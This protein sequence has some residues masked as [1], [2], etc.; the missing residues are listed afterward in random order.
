MYTHSPCCSSSPLFGVDTHRGGSVAGSDLWNPSQVKRF[1]RALITTL[2]SPFSSSAIKQL[3]PSAFH[4]RPVDQVQLLAELV[5]LSPSSRAADPGFDSRLRRGDFYRVESYQRLKDF[6]RAES[7]QRLRDFYRAESYQR[8]R[9]FYRAES[10]QRLRDFYRAESYQRLRDF[11]RAES[12]QRLRDIYRAE[13]YQR[14]KN[15][16]STG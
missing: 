2:C 13:S 9:D 10:Y 3:T 15:W 4:I 5:C 7:Y 14:L 12:Y 6:Y 1:W 11:Y 8:L 16:H